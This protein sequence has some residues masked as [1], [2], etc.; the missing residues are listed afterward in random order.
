[1]FVP[2]RLWFMFGVDDIAPLHW[3]K[4]WHKCLSRKLAPARALLRRKRDLIFFGNVGK[5]VPFPMN[6]VFVFFFPPNST[7]HQYIPL[8]LLLPDSPK[9]ARVASI[10]GGATAGCGLLSS[11][12]VGWG[13]LPWKT[14]AT[15]AIFNGETWRNMTGWWFGTWILFSSFYIGCHPSH[16]QTHI[17]QDGYCTTNQWCNMMKHVD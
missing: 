17:F 11:R 3:G 5:A 14:P 12:L 10:A 4:I 2:S 16:W 7:Y 13:K 6:Q 9:T 8:I 15:R 1:M